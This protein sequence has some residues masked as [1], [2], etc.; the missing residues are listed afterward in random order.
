MLDVVRAGALV[1]V[2]AWHWVFSIVDVDAG[3]PHVGNPVGAVPGLRALTWVLQVMPLFFLV[4]GAVNAAALDARGPRGF[5][6]RRLRRLLVPALPLVLP[7]GAV[8][9]WAATTGRAAVATTVVLIVSPLWFAAT[10]AALAVVAPWP[11]RAQRRLPRATPVALGGA[12]VAAWPLC[13]AFGRFDPPR[14]RRAAAWAGLRR[15]CRWRV[16]GVAPGSGSARAGRCS[17]TVPGWLDALHPP[18][19]PAPVARE[20]QPRRGRRGTR[21][22]SG[23]GRCSAARSPCWPPAWSTTTAPSRLCG[24]GSTRPWPRWVSVSRRARPTPARWWPSRWPPA[25]RWW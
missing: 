5:V 22:R 11:W 24:R 1:V 19:E 23:P 25:W 20:E 21:S 10:Y 9:L 12:V 17:G 3:G 7:A 13:A 4:G 16:A 2:V 15:C 18:P 8:W 14:R 6:G